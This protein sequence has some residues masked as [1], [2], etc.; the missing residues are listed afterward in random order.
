MKFSIIIPNFNGL[1]VLIRCLESVFKYAHEHEIIIVD[2]GSTDGSVGWIKNLCTTRDDI[3]G[4]FHDKN[5]GF[6]EAC[7]TGI[8]AATGEYIVLLNNDTVV[9]PGW[10]NSMANTFA[11]AK[12]EF[13]L[14]KIGAVGP[15]SNYVGGAQFIK[16][17][18]YTLDQ[19]P[20]AAVTFREEN[21]NSMEITGFLSGFCMMISN[22]CLTDVGSFD[23]RF[24]TGFFEDN[25]FAYRCILK[26]WSLVIDQSTFIHHEGSQTIN[27]L[28]VDPKN[29]LLSNQ[30]KFFE[31][32]YPEGKQKIVLISR[33]KNEEK[34]LPGFLQYNADVVDEIIILSDRSTDQTAELAQAHEKVTEVI[35]ND[36]EFDEIRDRALLYDAAG[37]HGADWIISLDADERLPETF[38]YGYAHKLAKP[39]DPQ[40]LGYMF[41][42]RTFWNSDEYYR[43]DGTFGKIRGCR[44]FRYIPGS[45][46]HSTG[47]KGLHC[48]HSPLLSFFNIRLLRTPIEHYG[49]V[50]EKDRF[51]KYAYYTKIDPDPDLIKTSPDGYKHI[52]SKSIALKKYN[53]RNTLGLVMIVKNESQALFAFL[54]QMYV[55]FDQIVIVDTGSRDNTAHVCSLFNVDY[56]R[57]RWQDSF[58]EARNFAKSKC[59]TRWILSMDPDE[60]IDLNNIPILFDMIDE[61]ID[62]WLFRVKNLQKDNSVI[63][64]D[65]CRLFLNIPEFEWSWRCHENLAPS[66][67]KHKLKIL[68]APFDINHFGFLKT[69]RSYN[70]KL[71]FYGRLLRKQIKE[72]PHEPLGYFH[73]AFHLFEEG[74]EAKGLKLLKKACSLKPE[75]FLAHK[76]LALRHLKKAQYEFELAQ[77]Y[78]PDGHYYKSWLNKVVDKIHEMQGFNLDG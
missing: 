75:F 31:K 32:Y 27:K 24:K 46:P 5:L 1:P 18:K 68:T 56:Y 41:N 53:P 3:L 14:E 35:I 16:Y 13:H 45:R 7:N 36:E 73:Y 76:E 29:L 59:T 10:L 25:D 63:L 33:M 64:S 44:F 8:S 11:N 34:N 78:T 62:G 72:F 57:H 6:A 40:I 70:Y 28:Q 23:T 71:K 77:K 55:Y 26:N 39:Y 43:A 50:D 19:L 15:L 12:K 37:A 22:K 69:G 2:D 47:H 30:L 4:L 52:I 38:T 48:T 58:S 17:D 51:K 9:T 67:T 42:F 21:K 49:Y 61:D 65:N 20:G 74:R 54:T 60:T 66:I